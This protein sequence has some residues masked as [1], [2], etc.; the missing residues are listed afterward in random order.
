MLDNRGWQ[1]LGEHREPCYASLVK[2]FFANM[3]SKEEKRLYVRG[4]WV[5]F[6]KKE[7]NGLFN[8]RVQK[9]GSKFKKQLKEPEHQKIID[10]L[11]A[12]KGKWKGTKK[13]PF[14]SNARGDQT[15]VA[16]VWL[17]FVSSFLMPSKHLSTVRREE[18]ILLYALL[19]G[20]MINVGKIIEKSIL[21]YSESKCKGMIPHPTIIT[22]LCIQE[23]V[24]EEWGTEETYPRAFPLK[25]QRIEGRASKKKQKNKKGI[26]GA[27][28]KNSG[29]AKFH[30][31]KK[32]REVK[33][34][35]IMHP[36]S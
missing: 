26:K 19:K 33:V 4:Q 17:N 6:N 35:S 28:S 34:N 1:S 23:G 31:N 8:L 21:G 15:E 5:K 7:I 36:Q 32:F 29:K 25:D 24:D 9:D 18:A 10:L 22:R 16:K 20:Y 14:K 11:M 3:V 13:T 2:E 27:L 12:G 30:C